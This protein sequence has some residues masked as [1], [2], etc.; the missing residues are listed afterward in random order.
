[1]SRSNLS[2]RA[3]ACGSALALVLLALATG[4]AAQAHHHARGLRDLA[5]RPLIGTAVNTDLL[6]TRLGA[7]A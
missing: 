1:M 6:E 2:R 3:W 5:A 7:M 4:P